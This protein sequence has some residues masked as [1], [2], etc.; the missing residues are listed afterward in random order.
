MLQVLVS[1]LVFL[2][3]YRNSKETV[4]KFTCLN[5]IALKAFYTHITR[6]VRKTKN[7]IHNADVNHFEKRSTPQNSVHWWWHL[8]KTDLASEGS[9]GGIT[10]EYFEQGSEVVDEKTEISMERI[11][12]MDLG[13]FLTDRTYD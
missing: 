10:R 8:N 13:L 5:R 3:P 12:P 11:K 4:A 1:N 6:R 7:E 2:L 9:K